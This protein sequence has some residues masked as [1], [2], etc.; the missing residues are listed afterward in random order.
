MHG[1]VSYLKFVRLSKHHYLLLGTV[2]GTVL[3]TV[4]GTGW[5]LDGHWLGTAGGTK[6]GP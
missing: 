1:I 6:A 2:M 3:G 4:M 5:A